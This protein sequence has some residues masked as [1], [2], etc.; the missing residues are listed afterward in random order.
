MWNNFI[1]GRINKGALEYF[2]H[3]AEDEDIWGAVTF[4]SIE[5]NRLVASIVDTNSIKQTVELRF[6]NSHIWD[7]EVKTIPI[8]HR[9]VSYQPPFNYDGIY[10]ANTLPAFEA[11]FLSSSL[12]PTNRTVEG[13]TA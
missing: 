8:A 3:N 5:T 6:Y 10:P 13:S 9:G 7:D 11:A 4:E 1:K 12:S 2:W